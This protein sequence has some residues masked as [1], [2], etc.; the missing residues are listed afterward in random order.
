MLFF[1]QD[2]NRYSAGRGAH[3]NLKRAEKA[4]LLVTKL[5]CEPFI[6]L[7]IWPFF[8]GFESFHIA[9]VWYMFFRTMLLPNLNEIFSYLPMF[10]EYYDSSICLII[11]SLTYQD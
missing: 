4:R 1:C 2:D 10:I 9:P 5:H 11:E 6:T 7:L 8:F 3:K